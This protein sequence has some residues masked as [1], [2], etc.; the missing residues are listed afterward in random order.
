MRRLMLALLV[1][2]SISASSDAIIVFENDLQQS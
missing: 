2:F 1:P